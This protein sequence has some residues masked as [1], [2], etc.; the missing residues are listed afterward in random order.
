MKNAFIQ[1]TV[2]LS[3]VYQKVSAESL[4]ASGELLCAIGN[5]GDVTVKDAEG[6]ELVWKAGEYH[7]LYSVDL[8]TIEVKG[9]PGDK[10]IFVG[11]TW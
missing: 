1:R 7:E 11:G 3:A 10:F 4:V 9:T 2:T 6:V 5:A 8:S